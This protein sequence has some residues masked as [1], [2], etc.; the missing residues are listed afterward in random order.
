MAH[1]PLVLAYR[2]FLGGQSW[3]QRAQACWVWDLG[4]WGF[5]LDGGWGWASSIQVL[6]LLRLLWHSTLSPIS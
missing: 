6:G 1:V 2:L 3:R 5:G 4:V